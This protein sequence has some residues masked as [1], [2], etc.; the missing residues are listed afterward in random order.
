MGRRATG[1]VEARTDRNCI[2]LRFRFQDA[3]RRETLYVNGKPIPPTPA[4][5]KY[6]H[7]LMA[8]IMDKIRIGA[9]DYA[10]YFPES[11]FAKVIAKKPGAAPL[12]HDLMDDWLSTLEKAPST[13]KQYVKRIRSFWKVQLP[14]VLVTEIKRSDIL[15]ALKA[16]T[17]K[18]AKSRN[19]ELSLING[20][21][22]YARG[23]GVI[24]ANP[25]ATIERVKHQAPPPDPFTQDEVE[26]IL[27]TLRVHY[28]EEIV[29]FVEFMFFSGLR[30]SEALYLKWKNID[31]NKEEFLVE[32]ANVYSEERDQTK[33]GKSR[34]VKLNSRALAVLQRQKARTF[35]KAKHVFQN[36]ETGKPWQYETLT[37]VRTFWEPTLRRCGVRYRRPYNMRHTYATFGL[38]TGLKP[39]FLAKQLG[40][41]LQ[42]FFTVYADWIS[43]DDDDREMQKMEEAIRYKRPE[44]APRSDEVQAA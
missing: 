30:T 43:G 15:K 2:R 34:K 19:N 22:E 17:W 27:E 38:M 9:F 16:G 44:S 5:L 1:Q 42:M 41:S 8:E 11:D 7:R 20:V 35:L 13:R 14:N 12:L 3:E 10:A 31:W 37:D 21:F 33:T 23:D 26:L 40:H 39:G 28:D 18:T 29:D 32:G 4:N 24:A 6:A 25:C 36:P